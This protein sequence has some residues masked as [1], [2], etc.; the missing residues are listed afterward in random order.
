M[1]S[2]FITLMDKLRLGIS[3]NDE[4][5]PDLVDLL[6]NMSRL[7]MIPQDFEGRNKVNH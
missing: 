5:Q 3:A 7:S 4:L 1:V 2:L 6:D